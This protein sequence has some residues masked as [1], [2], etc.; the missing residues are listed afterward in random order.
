VVWLAAD[1]GFTREK[2]SQEAEEGKF[3]GSGVDQTSGMKQKGGA[4]KQM[5]L[6]ERQM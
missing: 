1:S 3:M 4:E 2:S 6:L 5:T